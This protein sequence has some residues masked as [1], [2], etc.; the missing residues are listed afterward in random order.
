[1]FG[2]C[3]TTRTSPR[4]TTTL[5]VATTTWIGFD[6]RTRLRLPSRICFIL[7]R[8]KLSLLVILGCWLAYS[9]FFFLASFSRFDLANSS[10]SFFNNSAAPYRGWWV[11]PSIWFSRKDMHWSQISANSVPIFSLS[12]V[13]L[14]PFGFMV[15]VPDDV[16]YP[17]APS[18]TKFSPGHDARLETISGLTNSTSFD[19]SYVPLAGL[20]QV[21]LLN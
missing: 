12:S 19:I 2:L 17:P 14:A 11:S 13:T 20:T 3:G 8:R 9:H 10:L 18:V 1:M 7:T 16:W 4:R 21:T 6:L 5:A 15:L